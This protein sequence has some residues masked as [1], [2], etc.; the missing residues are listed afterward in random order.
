MPLEASDH[1]VH[2]VLAPSA[3]LNSKGHPMKKVVK[4]FRRD[5]EGAALAE[6][7]LLVALIAVVCVVAVTAL[8][9]QIS[10]AF[11]LIASAI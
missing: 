8:G 1:V 3:E 11:S 10:T 4:R 9:T 5:E 7:G 6:Y 2:T